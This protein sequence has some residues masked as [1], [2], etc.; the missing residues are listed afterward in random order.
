MEVD[1]CGMAHVDHLAW[2]DARLAKYHRVQPLYVVALVLEHEKF[3][4]L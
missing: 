2:Y 4:F 1:R 3:A